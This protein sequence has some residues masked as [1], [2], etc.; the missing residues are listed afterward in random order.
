MSIVESLARIGGIG[1]D[2]AL[3]DEL[4]ELSALTLDDDELYMAL[5]NS[6]RRSVIRTVAAERAVTLGELAERIAAD[7]NN[8]PESRITRQER[9]RVYIGLQ[10]SHLGKLDK[11]DLINYTGRNPI[12]AT[13][14]TRAAATLLNVIAAARGGSS[15]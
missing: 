13:D 8:K 15:E 3:T 11:H 14:Q 10:Q 2:P 12:A 7:E 6:R 9:K 4:D 1:S 5:K